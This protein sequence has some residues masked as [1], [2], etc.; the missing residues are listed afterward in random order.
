MV[1]MLF[2]LVEKYCMVSSVSFSNKLLLYGIVGHFSILPCI[3]TISC[4][5]HM[6]HATW[7]H[8]TKLYDDH[9]IHF[10]KIY[11]IAIICCSHP[12]P[13]YMALRKKRRRLVRCCY[14]VFSASTHCLLLL[15]IGY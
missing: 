3:L 4:S 14:S 10:V 12:K 2:H 8:G 6:P 13:I 1:Q 9:H 7:N 11:K 15:L 5:V